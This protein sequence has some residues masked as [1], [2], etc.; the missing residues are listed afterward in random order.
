MQAAANGLIDRAVRL[1][2]A[3]RPAEAKS[4]LADACRSGQ[5]GDAEWFLY[6]AALHRLDELEAALRAFSEAARLAPGNPQAWSAKAAV[7][8][9]LK[10]PDAALE[11]SHAALALSPNDPGLIFNASRV[12]ESMGRFDDALAGY[13]NALAHQP[14]FLPALLNRGLL[15]ACFQRLDAAHDAVQ[16]ALAHH[17]D[18]PECWYLLGDILFALQRPQEALSAFERATALQPAHLPA[19][20]GKALALSA[21]GRFDEAYAALRHVQGRD[22]NFYASYKS[23]LPADYV[24]P[25]LARDPRRIYC[26]MQFQRL[27]RCDWS[28]REAFRD[29]VRMLVEHPEG[30]PGPLEDWSLP[31][32]VLALDLEPD[33]RLNLA[34]QVAAG[35]KAEASGVVEAFRPASR[36]AANRRLRIGYVSPDFRR[37]ATAFLSRQLFEA[38]DRGRFEVLAYAL[39]PGDGSAVEASIRGG[40]DCYRQMAGVDSASL[41][42]RIRDDQVD[43][44]VDL[45]GYTRHARPEIFAARC[46]PV[47]VGYLGYPGT[48]GGAALDYAIVDDV[49]CPQGGDRF[50]SE[51]LVRLPGTYAIYDDMTAVSASTAR[52]EHGLP[53]GATVL[54]CFNTAWKIDP[55]IF[56]VWMRLLRRLPQ[57]V[58]W[59]W[60]VNPFVRDNLSREA[61]RAGVAPERLVFGGP[62]EHA[63]HLARYRHADFFLDTLPCNAHTTAADALWMGVPVVTVLGGQ[64]QGRVAASLLRA[65]GLPELVTASLADYETLAHRLATEPGVLSALRFRLAEGRRTGELFNTRRKVRDLEQAFGMMWQRHCSGLP[66]TGFAVQRDASA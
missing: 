56:E 29:N 46:A 39:Q 65:A 40:C 2:R 25:S 23:P 31:H 19:H 20:M 3:D 52:A 53:E 14:D 22:A 38:H 47:Q 34:R 37:H 8:L 54:C 36:A 26:A 16:A 60:S 49:V 24:E 13:E 50:W 21:L 6:G 44:L 4:L 51:S 12:L 63:A 45:A 57:S 55:G 18:Q 64:M 17:P 1:L 15:L 27:E 9:D 32:P 7:L 43:I 41:A 5:S 61:L 10:L 62:L 58:L 66:P 35:V 42:R 11:A 59:L 30:F 28:E 33:L 48:L